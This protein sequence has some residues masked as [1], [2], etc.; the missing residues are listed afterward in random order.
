M[1]VLTDFVVAATSEA[2]RVGE[3][4]CPSRDFN[5]IEAKGI[6]P[7]KLSTLYA[8]LT[9]RP[10]DPA[11]MDGDSCLYS[12]SDEGPWV[13]LVPADLVQRVAKLSAKEVSATASDWS[14]TDEFSPKHGRWPPEVIEQWLEE[15][16]R[17]CRQAVAEEKALLMWMSL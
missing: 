17:L 3:S 11:F 12:R 9:E 4:H 16:A 15:L 1:G 6:D 13:L 8:I 14:K 10:V 7:V 2:Q 5:G